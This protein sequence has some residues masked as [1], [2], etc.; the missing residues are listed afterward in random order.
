LQPSS[1]SP[2]FVVAVVVVAVAPVN[3]AVVC[4]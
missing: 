1:S 2:S 4:K 3:L